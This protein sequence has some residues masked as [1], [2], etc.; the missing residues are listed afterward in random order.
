MDILTALSA[1][2]LY[3]ASI[4]LGLLI[5][6][7]T[8]GKRLPTLKLALISLP[9]ALFLGKLA[10]RFIQNPRPFAIKNIQPLIP[11]APDNGFPSDHTLLVATIAAIVFAYDKKWGIV[12]SILALL[13]GASR[14]FAQVHNWLDI[15][16]SFVIAF[17]A[18]Y[19]SRFLLNYLR[20]GQTP[21]ASEIKS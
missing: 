16:G 19:I 17:T 8:K 11:H 18:V 7:L 3:L 10:N 20:A 15:A 12:L 2:Y 14:V 6:F 13:V 4:L 9:L 1:K 21:K 5:V